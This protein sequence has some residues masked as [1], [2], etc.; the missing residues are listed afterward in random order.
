M[1]QLRFPEGFLWGGAISG[2]QTEGA[3]REDGKGLSVADTLPKGIIYDPVDPP[4]EGYPFHRGIDFYHRY[5]QDIAMLAEMGF[6]VLRI[7]IQW[8]RIFPNGDDPQPNEAGLLFYDKLLDCIIA[9]GMQP[10]VTLSHFDLPLH[11]V[12]AYGGWKNPA[13]IALFVRYA[14]TVFTRYKD[15][16]QLWL[17][18]NEINHILKVPY[19]C[20]GLLLDG[21]ENPKQVIYQAAHRQLLASA[22]AVRALRSIAPQAK[23][24][25]MM[26]AAAYYPA[27]CAPED[28]LSAQQEQNQEQLFPDVQVLG[29]Y[30]YW[31]KPFWEKQ[32]IHVDITPD[33]EKLLQQNTMDYVGFSYY[34][35]STVSGAGEKDASDSNLFG[36][37]K[38]PYLQ[39][40]DWGWTIDPVGLR[41]SL[42][43]LYQ[44]YQKP[45]FIVENGLGA[46]DEVTADGSIQDD[47]RI[48]YLRQH[49]AQMHAAIGDGVTLWG[50][51]SWAPIDL[52]SVTT[53]EMSKRYGYI[54]VDLDNDGVGSGRRIRKK[55]FD[56]YRNVIAR[57]GLDTP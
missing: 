5:P 32:G 28:V 18:F 41:I 7:S 57:N 36:G 23:I 11:L 40:S 37:V 20:G 19:T 27:T 21:E 14:E 6:G 24:G 26:A 46:K 51:T 15:K 29:R 12:H 42:N 13:L 8:T 2:H 22:Q 43:M 49:I 39:Q 30:P 54:Y 52:V 48:D 55:S 17:T 35:S 4:G 31:V 25:C 16:V 45:L 38:N 10:M 50:Y 53:A 34:M 33:D 47:A 3:Y 56:W 1:S 9:H 44:R